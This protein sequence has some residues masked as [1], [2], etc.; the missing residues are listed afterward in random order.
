VLTG[1]R[2]FE[3]DDDLALTSKVLNEV[4]PRLSQVAAQPIPEALELLVAAC[5]EKNRDNRP[6]H[7]GEVGDVLEALAVRQRW[8]RRQAEAAWAA[9]PGA[10][11]NAIVGNGA[12][13]GAGVPRS[14]DL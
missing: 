9:R 4:P 3:T 14:A 8:T 5:L 11:E 2:I 7:I 12:G 13:A 10:Q 6:Q 1:R